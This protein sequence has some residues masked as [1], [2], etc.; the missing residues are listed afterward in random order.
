MANQGGEQL[1]AEQWW[2][3]YTDGIEAAESHQLRVFVRSY[4]PVS[5]THNQ[6]TRLLDFLETASNE[7]VVDGY[8]VTVLGQE[9]CLCRDC[10]QTAHT[11]QLTETITELR[12]WRDGSIHA[13]GFTD[14]RVDSSLIKEEYRTL[15]PPELAVGIYLDGTLSGVFPCATDNGS[16]S[17]EAYLDALSN[18]HRNYGKQ[19]KTSKESRRLR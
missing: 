2:E 9:V 8:S 5:G 11:A 3:E 13:T 17:V 10:Q 18:R 16:Y 4:A 6:R 7:G 19:Q 15:A 14:R 12:T 1:R